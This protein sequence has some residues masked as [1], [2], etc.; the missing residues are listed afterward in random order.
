MPDRHAGGEG[1]RHGADAMTLHE[2][3]KVASGRDDVGLMHPSLERPYT[4][5]EISASWR[6]CW[7]TLEEAA[8]DGW[9]VELL[10]RPIELR[11]RDGHTQ[12]PCAA[13]AQ[14][15]GARLPEFLG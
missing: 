15:T 5:R 7:F 6:D 14:A 1:A 12:P 13:C 2:A 9:T 10:V 4:L 3:Y 8:D 11:P